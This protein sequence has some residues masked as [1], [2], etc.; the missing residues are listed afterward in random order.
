MT[1][2]NFLNWF[3]VISLGFNVILGFVAIWQLKD[4]RSEKNRK[5]DQVKIWMQEANGISLG[6]QRIV[7]DNLDTR[8]SST[9]DIANAVWAL[10]ASAFSLRQS[11]YEERCVTEEEFKQQQKLFQEQ[12]EKRQNSEN[13]TPAPQEIHSSKAEILHKTT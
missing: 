3:S 13:N 9:Q 8:Y 4:A 2:T 11:L 10:E 12:L 7:R 1:V 5:K 6:L